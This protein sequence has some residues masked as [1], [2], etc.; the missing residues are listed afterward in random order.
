MEFPK[1]KLKIHTHNLPLFSPTSNSSIKASLSTQRILHKVQ[2]MKNLTKSEHSMSKNQNSLKL[3]PINPLSDSTSYSQSISKSHRNYKSSRIFP[4]NI[5]RN[6]IL[7]CSFISQKGSANKISNNLNQDSVILQTKLN[8]QA[9]QY[10]FGVFDG[11]GPNG[12]SISTLLKNRISSNVPYCP[13]EPQEIDLIEYLENTVNLALRTVITSPIDTSI[14][15][16]TLCLIIISGPHI[17][18]ANIGN[19]RC[20][21]GKYNENWGFEILSKENKHFV[22]EENEIIEKSR[23]FVSVFSNK[24]NQKENI[25]KVSTD[26]PEILGYSM[27]RLNEDKNMKNFDICQIVKH[28][29]CN[30]DKFLILAS[31][32]IWDVISNM[33]AVEIVSKFWKEG[34]SEFACKRLVETAIEKWMEFGDYIDD[35]SVVVVFLN[36]KE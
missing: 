28:K 31:D 2:Q 24:R 19:S 25:V 3:A 4:I 27:N 35:I 17:I 18:C 20:I 5:T 22:S 23:E 15:S 21:I 29:V 8:F 14:S 6:Y 9:Y 1:K 13:K 32:G 34:K 16:S 11:H 36:T 7:Q 10:L 12:H 33:E 26:D 30:K